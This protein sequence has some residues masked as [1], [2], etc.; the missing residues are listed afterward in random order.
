MIPQSQPDLSPRTRCPTPAAV[1]GRHSV[2]VRL[3]ALTGVALLVLASGGSAKAADDAF[4]APAPEASGPVRSIRKY[5]VPA[6]SLMR[7]DGKVVSLPDE[8][9]ED[10]KSTRLN[11]SH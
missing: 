1:G 2:F 6:V 3:A 10:R 9:S 7:D 11:S 8:M 5:A 4:T